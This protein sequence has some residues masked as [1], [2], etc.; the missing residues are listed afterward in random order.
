[1]SAAVF[2][3]LAKILD[4]W[5]RAEGFLLMVCSCTLGL[6][7]MAVCND[8]STFCAA[9]VSNNLWLNLSLKGLCEDP[10]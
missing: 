2:I 4:V 8:L 3:P 5:G 7:L 1:M 9:Y 10:C 6:V